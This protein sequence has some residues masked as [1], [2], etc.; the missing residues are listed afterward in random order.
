MGH[1]E[2]FILTRRN[3]QEQKRPRTARQAKPQSKT[4]SAMRPLSPGTNSRPQWLKNA[5]N[6]TTEK[7][8]YNDSNTK[9]KEAAIQHAKDTVETKHDK[10]QKLLYSS[11]SE[12]KN[13]TSLDTANLKFSPTVKIFSIPPDSPGTSYEIVASSTPNDFMNSNLSNS[14][15]SATEPSC[16]LLP[17]LLIPKCLNQKEL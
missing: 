4:K 17:T 10:N 6:R 13:I 1:E 15:K 11:S 8:P 14:P 9:S 5:H 3:Q 2:V 7:T 12:N 16:S